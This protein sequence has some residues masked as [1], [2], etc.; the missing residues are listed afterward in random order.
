MIAMSFSSI[1]NIILFI[2]NSGGHITV[3]AAC[4]KIW[5]KE[6]REKE[7]AIWKAEKAGTAGRL[8]QYSINQGRIRRILALS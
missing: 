7:E 8:V 3:E 4:E 2:R 1:S 6:R 5:L